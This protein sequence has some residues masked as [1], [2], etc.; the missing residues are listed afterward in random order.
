LK[1]LTR[2]RRHGTC[3]RLANGVSKTWRCSN[4]IERKTNNFERESNRTNERNKW[5]NFGAG[6]L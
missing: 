6:G 3:F 1:Y 2:K 4:I 5:V